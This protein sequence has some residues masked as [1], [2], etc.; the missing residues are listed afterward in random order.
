MIIFMGVAGSGKSMQGRML[1]DELGLPWLSTGEFLRMLIA[2]ERRKE[3]L[4]GQLLADKE[5]IA[6]VNK[7]FS[8][9]DIKQ[10][11][12]LDGFPRTIKQADWLLSQAKHGQLKITHVVH[13]TATEEVVRSRLIERGRQ[14]DHHDAI[15]ERFSEYKE[16][17]LP[18]L[19]EFKDAGVTVHTINGERPIQTVHSEIVQTIKQG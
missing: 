18:I 7:I 4:A 16:S 2:G 17:I 6:L 8:L 10:E 5:I 14:D 1:A 11:F 12:V 13:L 3:M 15:S 19:E 9:I